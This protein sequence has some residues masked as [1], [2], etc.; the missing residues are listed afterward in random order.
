MT[1]DT[2]KNSSE[3]REAPI[4]EP[5]NPDFTP[6]RLFFCTA[7]WYNEGMA[8]K[9]NKEL[10]DALNASDNGEVRAIDPTTNK[11]YVVVDGDLH[12]RAMTA[13][14]QQQDWESIQRGIAQADAGESIPLEE[15]DARIRKELGFPP[16]K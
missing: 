5:Q 7:V 15:A 9:L 4:H 13:L 14:Q 1:S 2:A 6:Y 8:P 12:Q 3:G 16:R 10:S 11:V